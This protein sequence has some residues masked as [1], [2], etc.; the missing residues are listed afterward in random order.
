MLLLGGSIAL[1]SL[2]LTSFC[3]DLGTFV[4]LYGV[5]N[6]LGTGMCYFVPLVCAWEYFPEK[7]GLITGVMLGA[8][9]FA[10]FFFGLLSTFV[11]NPNNA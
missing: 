9:G 5:T 3:T 6:G 10:S 4:F 2:F 7:Q 1:T 8:Y 11:V